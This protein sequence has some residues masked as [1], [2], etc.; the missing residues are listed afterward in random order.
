MFTGVYAALVFT[1]YTIQLGFVPR[2][3][4]GRPEFVGA[5][6]M[7]NPSSMAWFLE[8]FGYAAVGVATWLVA[9]AFGGG[10]R[11]RVVRALLV[12]NGVVSIAGAAFTALFDRWVFSTSGLVSFAAWNALIPVCFAI[13]ALSSD[14][15]FAG[16]RD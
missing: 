5:L 12:V 9:P 3:L 6:T 2:S 8:M 11:G 4:A 16:E 10:R 13:I 1:N 7:A 15:T 14:G